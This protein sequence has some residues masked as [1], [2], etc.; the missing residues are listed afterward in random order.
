MAAFVMASKNQFSSQKSACYA[1]VEA[2][3]LTKNE[4]ENL[5]HYAL[6]VLHLVE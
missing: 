4:I 6:K 2:L 5:R 3:A 1:Q